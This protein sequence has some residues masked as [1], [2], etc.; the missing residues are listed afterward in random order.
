MLLLVPSLAILVLALVDLACHESVLPANAASS[1][2]RRAQHALLFCTVLFVSWFAPS[3]PPMDARMA[4]SEIDD[5][6]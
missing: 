6:N 3:P 1:A 2:V 5:A 4:L